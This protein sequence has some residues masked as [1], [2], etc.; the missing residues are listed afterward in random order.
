MTSLDYNNID[1]LLS[2]Q[3]LTYKDVT[4]GTNVK[5]RLSFSCSQQI[6]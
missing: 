6:K 3:N 1:S 2:S 4:F 5:P